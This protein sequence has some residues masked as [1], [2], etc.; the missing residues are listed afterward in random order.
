MSRFTRRIFCALSVIACLSL[1]FAFS[2]QPG[3]DSD[4]VSLFVAEQFLSWLPGFSDNPNMVGILQTANVFVRKLGHTAEFAMLGASFMLFWY[5]YAFSVRIR[6]FLSFVCG[7]A[8][9]IGDEIHQLFVP[10]RSGNITDVLI[11]AIGLS[12]GIFLAR[13][14][15]DRFS[16]KNKKEE[17]A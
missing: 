17:K 13:T 9:A 12:I 4:A 5:Q 7:L 10:R 8:S 16:Q 3:S 15:A 1:I 11:D 6:I 14:V 2:S